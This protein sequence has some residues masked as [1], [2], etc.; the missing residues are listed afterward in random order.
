MSNIQTKS[1][2]SN[3]FEA[4]KR[5]VDIRDG[6]QRLTGYDP[7]GTPPE[8][9]IRC[10]LPGHEDKNPSATMNTQ[11]GVFYCNRCGE[12]GSVVDLASQVKR[13]EVLESARWLADTY[14]VPHRNLTAKDRKRLEQKW[15]ERKKRRDV[16]LEFIQYAT[17]NLED[18]HREHLRDR[19]LS[20]ETIEA[21]GIGY[22]PR[23]EPDNLNRARQ[24][25]LVRNNDSYLAGG[26]FIIPVFVHGEPEYLVLYDPDSD[27]KYMNLKDTETP[28]WGADSL[29]NNPVWFVEG[30]FDYLSLVEAGMNGLCALGTNLKSKHVQ[31]I[32]DSG[33]DLR[34]ALDSDPA[35]KDA[36]ND[37][38]SQLWPDIQAEIVHLPE[39][40][41]PN[42]LLVQAESSEQFKD[43]LKNCPA[44]TV[45]EKRMNELN[46]MNDLEQARNMGPVLGLI[47]DLPQI[48]QDAQLDRLHDQT[49]RNKTAL[50]KEMKNTQTEGD[51]PWFNLTGDFIPRQLGRSILEDDHFMALGKHPP[52]SEL[53]R[54]DNGVFK[55][56]GEPY[57]RKK[58]Q[59]IMGDDWKPAHQNATI[60][61]T[62]NETHIRR[63]ARPEHPQL[64]NVQNGMYDWLEDK[65]RTHSPNFSSIQQFPVEYDPDAEAPELDEFIREVIPEDCVDLLWEFVGWTLLD[66]T[67]TKFKK[68]LILTGEGNNG[69]STLINLLFE[70]PIGPELISNESLQDLGE[71]RF[72]V[73]NLYGKVAN[74]YADLE[75]DAVRYTGTFKILTGGDRARGEFK[76]KDPFYFNNR[77][78]LIFSCNELPNVYDYNEAFFDRLLIVPCPNEFTG[79]DENPDIEDELDTPEVRSHW[80]NKAVEGAR[81]L[82]DQG[83]FSVPETVDNRISN[84]RTRADSVTGFIREVLTVTRDPD[85]WEK[86]QH[87]YNEYR[88][89]CENTGCQPVKKENF[90]RRAKGKPNGLKDGRPRE[91]DREYCWT[92]VKL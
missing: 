12:G 58:I 30:P 16:M 7:N 22:E 23:S 19:G 56:G 81:R 72:S 89:W 75:S 25:G 29:G 71:N 38:A 66:D 86:K 54:Y 85:D 51:N 8:L 53:R 87:I 69:K 9:S 65:L 41:D 92:G 64:I 14:S 45:L 84:Y 62:K 50:R 57:A 32:K 76:G 67:D 24:I 55:R 43:T 77:A 11:Q 39:E 78:R 34:I 2:D 91:A 21:V 61:W 90:G 63:E 33:V 60:E 46:E 88:Q 15:Q 3:L 18:E 40:Q 70:R 68:S 37:I 28:L 1:A 59:D 5:H 6:Y 36:S 47:K 73:A 26:R 74:I 31:R 79:E 17:E 48:E 52:A 10:P 83:E 13:T 35:G 4:V 20:N 42:D 82:Y 80:F 44:K 49:G 27:R